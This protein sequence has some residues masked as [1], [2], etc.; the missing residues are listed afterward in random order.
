MERDIP[1]ARGK[2]DVDDVKTFTKKPRKDVRDYV[3]HELPQAKWEMKQIA[4]RY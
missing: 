4:L 3:D 1:E 2:F